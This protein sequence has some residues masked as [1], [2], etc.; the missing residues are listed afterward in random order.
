MLIKKKLTEV[1]VDSFTEYL[2]QK[3]EKLK[4]FDLDQDGQKDV[5]QIVEILGRCATKAKETLDTTDFP[6]IASGLE[7]ILRG[8]SMIR[9]SLDEKKLGELSTEL[10]EAS[11]K[12]TH[13]GQLTINYVKESGGKIE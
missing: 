1:A 6:G 3:F 5:D 2:Q 8:A 10:A 4:E 11:K 12:L 13:L 9:A 7:H